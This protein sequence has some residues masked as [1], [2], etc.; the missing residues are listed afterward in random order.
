MSFC[1]SMSFCL[2]SIAVTV[3]AL[4]PT[5][6]CR[7]AVFFVKPTLL[8]MSHRGIFN[9]TH[10]LSLKFK[11]K[12][13]AHGGQYGLIRASCCLICLICFSAFSFFLSLSFFLSFYSYVSLFHYGFALSLFFRLRSLLR[14]RSCSRLID[15][16]ARASRRN[17]RSL[18]CALLTYIGPN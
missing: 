17:V 5:R 10:L 6:L 18:G 12:R 13:G 9:K 15:L 3:T 8:S 1:P 7:I 16:C 2:C 11:T 14:G 4:P